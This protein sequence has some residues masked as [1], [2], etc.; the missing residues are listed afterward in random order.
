MKAYFDA[1]NRQ[2]APLDKIAMAAAAA[3]W[4]GI[5]KPLHGLGKLEDM[6][7][8]MAG[9]TG[10][11]EGTFHQR[12]VVVLCAD[13]GVVAEGVT[14]TD[15]SVTATM[16]GEIARGQSSVC[17]MAAVA[18]ADVFAVDMGMLHRVDG[19]EDRHIADGT[20]N[21]V[22]GPAMTEEQAYR[23][24]CHGVELV[25]QYRDRGYTLLVPGE[26]GIGNTTT[27]SA[28][29]AVLLGL[30]VEE[31]TG[32]GAGLS[33]AGLQR[34]QTAIR[35][36]VA[37]NAPHAED[38][39]DVLRKLGGFDMAA[40]AG[41]FLGGALYRVPIIIDGLI[42]AVAA[43]VAKRLCPAAGCAMLASHCSAEPAAQA[44]LQT[45]EM[46]AVLYA[47]L[48][49]GEGTGAVCLLPLLDMALAVYHGSA[50]FGSSGVQQYRPLGGEGV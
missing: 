28:V 46:E 20:A 18:G 26:M 16:A 15:A 8:Q 23:A 22:H 45:L 9:L 49:L 5:A 31:V 3:R 43:L 11:A 6:V 36:A 33:D 32:R 1:W 12:A 39:F 4:D 41:M 19:V 37:V 38:A 42:S 30:P 44:I 14:Q 34:K 24:L 50:T 29:A 17:R 21:I 27:S 13:N 10:T 25:K 2:I 35:Q 47:G 48:K 7:V 40:M